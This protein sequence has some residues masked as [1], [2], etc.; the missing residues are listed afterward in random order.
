MR[1]ILCNLLGAI[2]LALAVCAPAAA[3]DR[4]VIAGGSDVVGLNGIDVIVMSPDRFLMDHISDTLLGWEKPGQLGP[5]FATAGRNID[6]LTLELK[7]R[8]GVRF[9]NGQ[10]FDAAVV[11]VS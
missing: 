3:Q 9:P 2:A 7:L 10:P 4:V 1:K 8:Q 6:P 5:A 11:N